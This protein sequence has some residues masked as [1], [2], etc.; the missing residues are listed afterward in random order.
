MPLPELHPLGKTVEEIQAFI[1]E[2]LGSPEDVGYYAPEIRIEKTYNELV[3]EALWMGK[4]LDAIQID[5]EA[6]GAFVSHRVWR[7][8]LPK[9][10]QHV[11]VIER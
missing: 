5:R 9:P 2:L 8:P 11:E 7:L 6:S 3:I 4:D 10:G 1:F